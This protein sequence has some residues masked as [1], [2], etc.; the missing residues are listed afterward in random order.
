MISRKAFSENDQA[1][2]SHNIVIDDSYMHKNFESFLNK[3]VED[4]MISRNDIIALEYESSFYDLCKLAV[5]TSHTRIVIYKDNLDHIIGFVHIKDV[6]SKITN[7]LNKDFNNFNKDFALVQDDAQGNAQGN[8]QGKKLVEND[9]DNIKSNI[10]NNE[11]YNLAIK[12]YKKNPILSGLI[13]KL[14]IVPYSMSLIALLEEMKLK[15]THIAII[16]DEYGSSDGLLTVNDL[17]KLIIGKI[18]GEH[19]SVNEDESYEIIKEGV[20]IVNGRMMLEQ[21]EE[22]CQI[23][24]TQ[25]DDEFDTVT[26]LIFSKLQYIPIKE[27]EIIINENLTMK[28]LDLDYPIINKVKVTY[29]MN[30]E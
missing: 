25:E 30:A 4:I 27:E 5:K 2:N 10:K 29:Q 3:R 22:I 9:T 24:I 6:L 18:E 14:V 11:I 7:S 15:K 13:R 16:V 12:D 8:A 19:E 20:I 23:K 26:G 1:V 17:F 28:I 21:L